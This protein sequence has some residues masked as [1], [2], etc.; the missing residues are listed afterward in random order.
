MPQGLIVYDPKHRVSPKKELAVKRTHAQEALSLLIWSYPH[1]LQG[2]E[3]ECQALEFIHQLST[4]P[5]YWKVTSS[6]P[7]PKE[8]I[9]LLYSTLSVAKLDLE[10][11]A[12]VYLPNIERI[13]HAIDQF[14]EHIESKMCKTRVDP[15]TAIVKVDTSLIDWAIQDLRSEG[16]TVT[17]SAWGPHITWVNKE[18]PHN[19]SVW[20]NF[21]NMPIEFQVGDQIQTNGT[22]YWLDVKCDDLKRMRR[23]LGLKPNPAIDLHLTIG[24][25][26]E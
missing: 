19:K 23:Q 3:T 8:K 5:N 2:M 4:E 6:N 17:K 22:Y 15:W 16:V 11:Y 13:I 7:T 25:R 21:D 12:S 18:E 20:A 10:D 9:E 26:T 1:L 24:K 14:E